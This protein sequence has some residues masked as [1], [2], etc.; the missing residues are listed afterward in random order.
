MSNP[1]QRP[2]FRDSHYCA[3]IFSNQVENTF[4]EARLSSGRE[5]ALALKAMKSGAVEF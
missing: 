3:I 2:T 4:D 1:R 5:A